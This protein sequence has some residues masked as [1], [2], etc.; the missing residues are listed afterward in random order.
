MNRA[1]E[2]L[3]DLDTRGGP[4]IVSPA[5]LNMFLFTASDNRKSWRLFLGGDAHTDDVGGWNVR[6]GPGLNLKPSSQLQLSL[7][8]DYTTGRD[9]AQWIENVDATGDGVTDHVYGRLNRDIVDLTFRATYAIH[10]DLT[11]QAFL[12]PF[13]A[14]GDFTDIRRL[15]RP[16]SFEFEPVTIASNPDFNTKSLRGNVVL[17]WEYIRGSTLFVAWNIAASDAARPGRFQPLRD[18]RDAFGGT[19]TQ[20]VMVKMT[21]WMSR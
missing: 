2:A 12:Q 3:D 9:V 8:L 1:F 10:R 4:P 16:R 7:N 14:V 13:V 19:G 20:A 15:A 6:F 18:L 5:G 17:R 11:L 21:Y